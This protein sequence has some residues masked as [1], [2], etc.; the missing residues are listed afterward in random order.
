MERSS[1]GREPRALVSMVDTSFKTKGGARR[2]GLAG[3]EG[4]G[5]GTEGTGR[6]GY[7]T[8]FSKSGA[9][10]EE[11]CQILL[12]SFN[13]PSPLLCSTSPSVY[14]YPSFSTRLPYAP[15][16]MTLPATAGVVFQLSSVSAAEKQ[17]GCASKSIGAKQRRVHMVP[18]NNKTC[19]KRKPQPSSPASVPATKDMFAITQNNQMLTFCSSVHTVDDGPGNCA[20]MCVVH[21]NNATSCCVWKLPGRLPACGV[22]VTTAQWR[23]CADSGGGKH[24]GWRRRWQGRG[25]GGRVVDLVRVMQHLYPVPSYAMGKFAIAITL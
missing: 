3:A 23:V 2:A 9:G 19:L 16:S 14:L 13:P 1:L 15:S 17:L 7:F 11:R 12:H 10:G 22:G 18:A 4:V 20:H 6:E 21:A 5:G 8:T 24:T 25:G